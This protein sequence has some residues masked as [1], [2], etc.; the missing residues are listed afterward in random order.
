MPDTGWP[1]SW[2]S[3][4]RW[5]VDVAHLTILAALKRPEASA[6]EISI[7]NQL[8]ST[9]IFRGKQAE[10]TSTG[11][12]CD[13]HEQRSSGRGCCNTGPATLFP[14]AM[15]PPEVFLD[16]TFKLNTQATGM[17]RVLR[18]GFRGVRV[19]RASAPCVAVGI[20]R[21]PHLVPVLSPSVWWTPGMAV[22]TQRPNCGS[23]DEASVLSFP[24][25][26]REFGL[27]VFRKW[28]SV[29]VQKPSPRHQ[30]GRGPREHQRAICFPRDHASCI[31][32]HARQ[33]PD[34]QRV[35]SKSITSCVEPSNVSNGGKHRSFVRRR[36]EQA[37]PT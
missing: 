17:K 26:S 11:S 37:T 21:R 6:Q 14:F 20:G 30:G 27:Q 15:D 29:C 22:T 25:F 9:N 35:S 7:A 34:L 4:R 18:C 36:I 32:T 2:R 23:S 3:S 10:P 1:N 16:V 28:L 12:R 24:K 19:V 5:D 33:S 13:S 8:I 31:K